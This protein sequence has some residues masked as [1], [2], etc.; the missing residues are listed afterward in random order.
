MTHA[1]PTSDT[2]PEPIHFLFERTQI[3]FKIENYPYLEE[4]AYAPLRSPET[5]Y[6]AINLKKVLVYGYDALS[7]YA[8]SGRFYAIFDNHSQL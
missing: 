7:Q 3:Q 1:I 8:R 4:E 2:T 5:A 6:I